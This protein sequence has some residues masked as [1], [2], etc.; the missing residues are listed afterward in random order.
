MTAVNQ[1]LKP[2]TRIELLNR[3]GEQATIVRARKASFPVREG[4]HLVRFADGGELC[5]HEGAFRV[6]AKSAA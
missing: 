2:G 6:V 4:Y 3:D 1:T 5:I